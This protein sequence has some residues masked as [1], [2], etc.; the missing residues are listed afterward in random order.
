MRN[1]AA[2]LPLECLGRFR[3]MGT[4]LWALKTPT[5]SKKQG[6]HFGHMEVTTLK[7]RSHFNHSSHGNATPS[8][9]ITPVATIQ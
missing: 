2:Y 7:L 3:R 6:S 4:H 9:S 5:G 1:L 8:S